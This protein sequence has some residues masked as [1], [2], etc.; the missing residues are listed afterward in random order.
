MLAAP[1][2][3]L[4][5]IAGP[6]AALGRPRLGFLHTINLCKTGCYGKTLLHHPSIDIGA[7]GQGADRQ[8]AMI[9]VVSLRPA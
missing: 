3:R 2:A 8:N 7:V 9:L 5:E 1:L 4:R 6:E